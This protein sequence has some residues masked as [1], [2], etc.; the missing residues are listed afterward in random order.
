[1]LAAEAREA[2]EAA[3]PGVWVLAAEAREALE[4]AVQVETVPVETVPGPRTRVP[5]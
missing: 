1:V 3:V 4:A 5:R 2:L